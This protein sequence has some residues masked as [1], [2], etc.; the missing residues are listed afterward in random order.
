MSSLELDQRIEAVRRFNRFYTQKI[1]VLTDHMHNTPFT[2][3]EA[4][5]LFEIGS[6]EPVSASRLTEELGIDPGYLSRLLASFE[7]QRLIL[8]SSPAN[9]RRKRI[10]ELAPKG[11]AVFRTLVDRARDDVRVL[12]D[13]LSDEKQSRVV[14]AMTTI[15]ETL[16]ANHNG[17]A[18]VMTRTHRSGDIGWIIERHGA[19]YYQEHG[20]DQT[21]ETLVARILTELVDSF[22]EE[23][24]RIWIA[25]IDGERVGCI[26]AARADDEIV[27]L[28]LFLVEPWARGRGVGKRL[29]QDFLSFARSAGYRKAVLW[30]NSNLESARHLY[31]KFGFIKVAEE[32]HHSFGHDLVGENWELTL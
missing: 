30:T 5:L 15:R 11:K 17:S 27:R 2:L 8:R 31:E 21:F 3:T 13:S 29:I 1:G 22:E 23:K 18:G 26:L 20:W 4:R 28:R 7:S 12:L 10:S 32:V 25:E 9:D 19:I 14:R 24:D 6:R 16:N